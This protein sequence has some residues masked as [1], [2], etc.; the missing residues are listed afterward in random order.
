MDHL[1]NLYQLFLVIDSA[2]SVTV[3][4]C[5][6]IQ[7]YSPADIED[8]LS[9]HSLSRGIGCPAIVNLHC[10]DQFHLLVVVG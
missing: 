4:N 2:E 9:K 10:I 6:V 5:D 1:F 7:H 8:Y 3:V